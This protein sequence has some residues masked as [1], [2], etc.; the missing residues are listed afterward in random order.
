MGLRARVHP[1]VHNWTPQATVHGAQEE[2]EGQ[3]T[4]TETE[5]ETTETKTCRKFV[6]YDNNEKA[7]ARLIGTEFRVAYNDP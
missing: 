1:V 4:E 2:I 5:N 6:K 7:A 3:E